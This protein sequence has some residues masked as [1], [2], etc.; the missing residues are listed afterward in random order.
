MNPVAKMLIIGGIVLV[1]IGLIWQVG[2]RFL[3]LGRL[4]GD[5]VVEK[6][7]FRFYFPVMT[8]IILSIVLSLLF[9]LFRF[10]R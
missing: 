6:E 7:N 9:Y 3:N 2:G 4:P 8:S 1:I 10:F 5:I